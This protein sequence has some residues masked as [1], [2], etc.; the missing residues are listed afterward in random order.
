MRAGSVMESIGEVVFWLEV[1]WT[2]GLVLTGYLLLPR[3]ED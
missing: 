3:P 2:P 1:I